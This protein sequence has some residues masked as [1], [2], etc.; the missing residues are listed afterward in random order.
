MNNTFDTPVHAASTLGLEVDT[1][2]LAMLLI[3][4]LVAVGVAVCIAIFTIRYRRGSRADRSHPPA[5]VRWIE[6]TWTATP[7]A[8]FLAIFLWSSVVFSKFYN[9]PRD[10]LRIHVLAKQWMWKIEHDNGR[11]EIDQLHV[12]LGR[13]VELIMTSQDVIHSFF[14]PAFR[15]KQDVLPGRYTRVWFT[16]TRPGRFSL[17]CAEYCGTNHAGM[18]GGVIVMRPPDYARWLASAPEQPD[19]A[20]RGFEIYRR[21]GCSGCHEPTST[22][23]A[24]DL[25]GLFGR[26]V[27][28]ADGST[29][30][31][32]E[33]YLRDSILL[34]QKQV[35]AG[36]DPVMPSF[37]GQ[38]GEEDLVALLAFIE[39]RDAP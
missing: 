7:L 21:A 38:L 32:D 37:Q 28:L 1:L 17:F 10:S 4:G 9:P 5:R 36:F 18:F 11:R 8:I 13:P 16:A 3:T 30:M 25:H 33:Q 22:V 24:P 19:L 20:T 34:P 29:V 15:L 26:P 23:H 14:V 39:S 27:H 12:P 35:V 6:I 2:F 31:A